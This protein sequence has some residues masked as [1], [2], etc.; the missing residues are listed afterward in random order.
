MEE[1]MS[2]WMDRMDGCIEWMNGW[3]GGWIDKDHHYFMLMEVSCYS[4]LYY[5]ISIIYSIV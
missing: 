3:K 4:I 2:R 5:G 1:Y